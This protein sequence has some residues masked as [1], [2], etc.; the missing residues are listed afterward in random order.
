MRKILALAVVALLG[1]AGVA[2]AAPKAIYNPVTGN[3][4]F[5]NDTA[6]ALPAAY[7]QSASANLADPSSLLSIDGAVAD[8]ADFPAGYTYLNLPVGSFNT[9]NTVKVGTPIADLSFG[10]YEGSLTTPPKV[11]VVELAAVVPEPATLAMAGLGM[12]GFVAMRRRNG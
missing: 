10:Y 8:N 6:A 5:V 4:M 2:S 9:G 7:L 1:F 12:I 11:G 3:V